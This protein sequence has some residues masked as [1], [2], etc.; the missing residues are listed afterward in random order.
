M[1]IFTMAG[2][3]KP[4]KNKFDL[5]HER[6]TSCDFG[7]LL[8][9]YVEEVLP[10]DS[11]RVRTELLIRLAPMVFPV[12][13]RI[14]AYVHYFYVPNRLVWD[15]WEDFITG[16]ED[17]TAT[18]SLPYAAYEETSK[19]RFGVGELADHLG[20]PAADGIGAVTGQININML[21]FKA[22]A[23]IW[24]EYYRDQDLQTE[25]EIYKSTSGANTAFFS[26]VGR[27]LQ[28]RCFEKDYFTSARP[29]A[30]K[31]GE[32]VLTVDTTDDTIDKMHYLTTSGAAPAA[33]DTKL[34]ASGDL[35]DSAGTYIELQSAHFSINDLRRAVKLQEWLEKN[36]R[37]GN[38]YTEHLYNHFGVKNGDLRLMRP[39]YLG[40]GKQ[41][42]S[43]SEV[44][45]HSANDN[46]TLG[47]TPLGEMAGHGI[48]VGNKNG[49]KASFTEHG[50]VIGILSVIPRTA[51]QDGIPRHLRYFDK[52]DYYIPEFASIGEEEIKDEELY[53]P[54]Q[55]PSSAGSTFGYQQRYARY[56]Y[57][58]DSVH[59]SFRSDFDTWHL[60]R[61]FSSPPNLNSDFVK[62]HY[63]NEGFSRIFNVTDT[64]NDPLWI[65]VYNKVDAIRPM[66]YMAIPTL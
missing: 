34:D 31:G 2:S 7:Q 52:F 45:S 33:G 11:F 14:N 3:V 32:S 13:H 38:R 27:Y 55:N 39:Q 28:R 5:S 17:G 63:G 6:K 35:Q 53:L 58:S 19:G 8:P 15:E 12:M 59:G 47:D 49:F 29:W 22:Y 4:P 61:K 66:P 37:G 26:N 25:L 40:G 51:Y 48:V 42:V 62:C 9:I 24:N 44:V 10:G 64:A 54:L 16:G 20:F 50:Y 30:Q 57:K 43:I 41:P 60:G 56:K 65:Q 36:A 23:L 1:S 46:T 18:P 21:P